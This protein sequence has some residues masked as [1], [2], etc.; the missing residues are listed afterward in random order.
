MVPAHTEQLTLVTESFDKN[1]KPGTFEVPDYGWINQPQRWHGATYDLN[2]NLLAAAWWEDVPPVWGITGHH[3]LTRN[4]ASYGISGTRALTFPANQQAHFETMRLPGYSAPRLQ[5]TATRSDA[6]WVWRAPEQ[7]P[8]WAQSNDVGGP[9]DIMVLTSGGLLL[10]NNDPIYGAASGMLIS[11]DSI[12]S[13]LQESGDDGNGSLK[14]FSAGHEGIEFK[15]QGWSWNNGTLSTAEDNSHLN[16][17]TLLLSRSESTSGTAVTQIAAK[18]AHFGGVV[19]VEGVL[20]VNPAGDL[21]MG[22][23]HH[24]MKPNGDVDPGN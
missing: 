22:Q 6:A 3:T 2:R 9:V 20:R 14:S 21:G 18:S 10:P 13:N 7:L 15:E 16:S 1:V 8:S 23:F 24:G 17:N 12:K 11:H 5:F 19:S 4:A